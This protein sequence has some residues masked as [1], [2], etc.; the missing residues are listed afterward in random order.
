VRVLARD[1]LEVNDAWLCD[2]GRFAF[3]FADGPDRLTTPLLR[4]RGMEPA[5]F[6]EVLST[7]AGWCRDARVAFLTGGRLGNEDA[8]VLSKLARTVVGTNDLD[9]R[10]AFHG[11]VAEEYSAAAPMSVT[12]RDVERAG[13]I[14]VVGLDAEQELPILHL[15]IRKAARRGAKVFVVHSRRTRLHDLAEHHLVRPGGEGA[16]LARIH[17][18]SGEEDAFEGRVAAAL[19]EAGDRAVVLAGPRLAEHPLAADVAISVAARH[20]ARFALL[21]RRANDRGELRAGIHPALLPGGRR[22]SD[23][24]ERAEVEAVWGAVP[25]AAGRSTM[26]I[27]E[28]AVRR[29]IDVLFLVGV[30]P[31]RDLPD[32]ALVR[33]ALENTPFKVVQGLELGALEPYADAFLPA[34]ASLEL[35]GHTTTWEGREQRLRPVRPPR[36]LARPDREIL[37]ELARAM[38]GDLGF[39]TLDEIREEMGGL[40]APRELGRR[41]SAWAGGGT[42]QWIEEHTLFT[43]PLLVDEGSLG[44]DA[45]ELKES[46]EDPAFAEVHPESAA[47]HGLQDG[48]RVRLRTSAGESVLPLHVTEHVA[49]GSVFVPFNQPGLAANTLLSGRFTAAVELEAAPADPVPAAEADPV[50]VRGGA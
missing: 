30:D 26:E 14:L 44:R 29:E 3:R 4:G 11:G 18:A 35:E 7:V 25:D 47:K 9:H 10:R 41:A 37:I 32:A 2:K 15:R 50:L 1:N 17:D 28:A 42:P 48:G 24:A 45:R 22:A 6:D 36:G 5:P 49:A 27:L 46:L 20:G 19:A 40:L 12:Y 31:L 43:Y 34:A 38:G 33:R 13:A 23:A 21:S 39:E 8:Y 16:A